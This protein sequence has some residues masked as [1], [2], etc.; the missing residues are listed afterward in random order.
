MLS[1]RLSLLNDIAL[2][3][4][5]FTFNQ[6]DIK[7][8]ASNVE[9]VK[10]NAKHQF[11]DE[12]VVRYQMPEFRLYVVEN[13]AIESINKHFYI[14]I[15]PASRFQFIVSNSLVNWTEIGNLESDFKGK[16][17]HKSAAYW[18][19]STVCV[20]ISIISNVRICCA[21]FYF[22]SV[23]HLGIGKFE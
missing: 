16:R 23:E 14:V 22:A 10:I 4:C 12:N 17:A 1:Q 8:F 9:K 11:P 5:L 19:K 20:S 21:W 15:H 6:L 2:N 13:V 3:V 18:C 7:D